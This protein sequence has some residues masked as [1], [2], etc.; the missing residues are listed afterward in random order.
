MGFRTTP[1]ECSDTGVDRLDNLSLGGV[2]SEGAGTGSRKTCFG[3]DSVSKN[4]T[5]AWARL[6]SKAPAPVAADPPP[7]PPNQPLS[8]PP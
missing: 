4:C 6:R 5:K 2:V 3:F 1:A 8:Q 7:P